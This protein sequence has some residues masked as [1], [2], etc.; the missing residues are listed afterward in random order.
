MRQAVGEHAT[1]HTAAS[2]GQMGRFETEVF[3]QPD[4]LK[5]LTK[6]SGNWIER[7]RGRQLMRELTLREKLIFCHQ[8]CCRAAAGLLPLI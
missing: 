6:L 4:K 7:V 1:E 5:A 2:T 8:P 3:T